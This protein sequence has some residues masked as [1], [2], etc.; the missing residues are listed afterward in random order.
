MVQNTL[1]LYFFRGEYMNKYSINYND[2]EQMK[3]L[4]NTIIKDNGIKKTFIADNLNIS[5]SNLNSLLNKKNI[6]LDD[7]KKICDVLGYEIEI[8]IKKK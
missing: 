5:R 4:I 6:T 2:N 8:N 7:L 1:F 3:E